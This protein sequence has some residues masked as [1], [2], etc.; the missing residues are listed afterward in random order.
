MEENKIQSIK[1]FIDKISYVYYDSIEK[2][3]LDVFCKMFFSFFEENINAYDNKEALNLL[4]T[5]KIKEIISKN[6]PVFTQKDELEREFMK[7]SELH[8]FVK[9]P[10]FRVIML[11]DSISNRNKEIFKILIEQ[12]DK[13]I[14]KFEIESLFEYLLDNDMGKK[15]SKLGLLLDFI[16]NV[17]KNLNKKKGIFKIIF[18]IMKNMYESIY[19]AVKKEKYDEYIGEIFNILFADDK[20][21]DPKKVIDIIEE[22]KKIYNSFK[23]THRYKVV[24]RAIS[25]DN[26]IF[27]IKEELPS[28]FSRKYT[29]L[30]ENEENIYYDFISS[31]PNEFNGM[32]TFDTLTKMRHYEV[33]NRLL[34]VTTDPLL[35]LFFACGENADG[36]ETVCIYTVKEQY[37]KNYD[38]DTVTVLTMLAK[39]KKHH[40]I[41]LKR[42]VDL[43]KNAMGRYYAYDD[44]ISIKYENQ[45]ITI[46]E[47]KKIENFE[48]EK[49]KIEK[50]E[51][52]SVDVKKAFNYLISECVGELIWKLKQEIPGWYENI[53]DLETFTNCYLVKPKMN[54]PRIMAQSGAFFIYPFEDTDIT[55]SLYINK[56]EIFKIDSLKIKRELDLLNIKET[57]YMPDDLT[58]YANEIRKKYE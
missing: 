10:F 3:I 31:N 33:P 30:K 56:C 38:S 18:K 29:S 37:I 40:R 16:N 44:K 4:D 26:K 24:F 19:R 15:E 39:L 54:N 2:L 8:I 21:E 52:G 47:I 32:T 11:C 9:N 12:L 50:D 51:K 41:K 5:N 25:K 6:F 43:F 34:D 36:S 42:I 45:T 53:L 27:S 7:V 20:R 57:K 13:N 55:K 49:L 23:D 22:V 1:E 17:E 28:L 46:N 35:A 14:N 48:I 58:K